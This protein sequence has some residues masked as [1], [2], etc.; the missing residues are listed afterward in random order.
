MSSATSPAIG[1]K[2][3][4]IRDFR[5]IASLN[6]D[7]R[8]PDGRPNRLVVLAGPNGCGKTTVLEAALI[9]VG[10]QAF[11]VGSKG[12]KGIR[13]EAKDYRIEATIRRDFGL[14]DDEVRV[15]CTSRHES[16]SPSIDLPFWYFSSWRAPGLVGAV[17]VT[18]GKPGRRPKRNDVN[19]LKNVKQRFTNAAAA[20]SFPTAKAA[21]AQDYDRWIRRIDDAW[22]LFHSGREEGFVVD[23][24]EPDETAG[25]AFDIFLRRSDGSLLPIDDLSSGQLELFLFLAALVLNDEGEGIVFIDEPELHL[26][27]QWHAPLLRALMQ[28]QPR[29]QFVVATHSPA[30]FDTAKSYERHFLVPDDD[31]RARIWREREVVART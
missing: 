11:A 30:V 22:G 10:G 23:L 3:L 17:D 13:K 5:G 26:D 1:L 2:T 4:S 12:R 28:L 14:V 31:P 27:P 8:R 7:F 24:V 20:K 18:V 16:P 19:R 25:G 21:R 29:A 9:S 15:E 6:L